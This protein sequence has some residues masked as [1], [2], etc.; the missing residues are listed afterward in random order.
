MRV[1]AEIM[2]FGM[3]VRVYPG[4]GFHFEAG[5]NEVTFWNKWGH[6]EPF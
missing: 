1:N 4:G 3:E 5:V 6:F 2:L